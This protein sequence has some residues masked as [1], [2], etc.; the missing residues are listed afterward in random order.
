MARFISL[1][2]CLALFGVGLFVSA[3]PDQVWAHGGHKPEALQIKLPQVVAQ[4]NG[5]DISSATI[6]RELKKAAGQYKRRGMPLSVDQEKAAAKKLIDDEI[7][8][9]LLVLKA[10]ASGIT[11]T[12]AMMEQRLKEVQAQFRSEAVFA[13]KLADQG[14]SLDQYKTELNT[15]LYMDR[16]IKK[17][18]EPKIQVPES[19]SRD[20]YEKNKSKFASQEKIRASIILLKFNPSKGKAGEQDV[21]KKFESILDQVKNGTDFAAVARKYSEDS[22]ATKGG[23]L[24]FFTHKQMLPAFSDRAFKM[25]VGEVSDIFRTGHGFHVLKVTDKKPAQISPFTAEKEKIESFL[26]QKQ[27]SQATRDYIEILKKQAKIKTY[28]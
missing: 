15:D 2:Y 27:V 23:D 26:K 22:L 20:Y 6:S 17:E 4:V 13:H 3:Q 25:K 7:G 9:T 1:S 21:L 19:D 16:I 10:K 28:F 18:I 5:V 14:M 8:R 11:I 12:K 24:G